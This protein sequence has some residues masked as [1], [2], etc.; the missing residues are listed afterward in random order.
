MRVIEACFADNEM[1]ESNVIWWLIAFSPD[2][3]FL[4]TVFVS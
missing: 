2:L 3:L 1:V 4:P